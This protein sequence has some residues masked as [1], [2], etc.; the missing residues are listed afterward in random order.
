MFPTHSAPNKVSPDTLE[1]FAN[2]LRGDLTIFAQTV[3]EERGISLD[4]IMPLID[5]VLAKPIEDKIN[6]T[7]LSTETIQFKKELNRFNSLNLREIC[8]KNSLKITGSREEMINRISE[9]LN[10]KEFT[11]QE[12]S[13]AKSFRS[14]SLK[15]RKKVRANV[16]LAETPTHFVS[17]SD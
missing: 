13:C 10:L 8:R 14:R 11:Q 15:N 5:R 1:L 6:E 7:Y 16:N 12:E 3:A 2:V 9:H 17:D 4:D